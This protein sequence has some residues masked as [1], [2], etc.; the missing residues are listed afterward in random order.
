ML[1]PL[2]RGAILLGLIVGAELLYTPTLRQPP[3]WDDRSFVFGQSFLQDC[4]NLKRVL[5]LEGFRGV[6]PV[7]GTARPVWLA[8]VLTDTCLGK[9]GSSI[10]RATSIFWHTLG[11]LLLAFITFRLTADDWTALMSGVLF[12]V[13]PLHV[14]AVA[15]ITYRSELLCLVFMLSCV[16]LHRESRL[17]AGWRKWACLTASFS[18]AAL[19]LLSKEMASVLPFLLPLT[20]AVFPTGPS[21][22]ARRRGLIAATAG[23]VILVGLYLVYRSPRSGYVMR[24]HSDIFSEL[25]QKI[26]LPFSRQAVG[27]SA[28]PEASVIDDPPWRQ[29][30]VDPAARV[31]TMSR[32]FGSYLRR[33]LLPWPLQG[34]YAP[35]VVSSWFHYGVLVSWMS[36]AALLS[37]AWSLRRRN[38]LASYG[39]FWTLITL[40]P[41]SGL[42]S[43]LNLEA[44]RYLYIPSAGACLAVAAAFRWAGQRG[45]RWGWGRGCP[46]ARSSRSRSSLTRVWRSRP[47]TALRPGAAG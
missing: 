42:V 4:G 8:S 43:I 32:I 16:L 1:S 15:I 39:I 36:W 31:R 26:E 13:H 38:P 25:R 21:N 5:S 20:D 18:A 40:L 30:Y 7:R 6:L 45:G 9:S 28:V 47:F 19:A 33:L 24:H 2:S 10:Y 29:V 22:S 23:C 37:L 11:A 12:S 34:D 44:D 14:E 17:R 46:R 41:V 35:A 3:I 27:D